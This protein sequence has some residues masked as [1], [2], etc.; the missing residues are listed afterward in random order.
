MNFT[1]T[2]N[3]GVTLAWRVLNTTQYKHIARN[4]FHAYINRSRHA[5]LARLE[6]HTSHKTKTPREINFT[7]TSIV[8]FTLAWRD[9][10]ITQY[11]NTARNKFHAY[12]TVGVT[13]AWRVLNTTQYSTTARNKFHAYIKRRRHAC[14]ARLEHHS[15]QTHR[16]K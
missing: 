1:P 7:P 15:I 3:V 14:L 16:A 9:L 10:N 6:H 4:K 8:G 5:C 13:L 2:S 11:K 12:I